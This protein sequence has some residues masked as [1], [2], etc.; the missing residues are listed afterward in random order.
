MKIFWRDNAVSEEAAARQALSL[1]EN[2]IAWYDAGCGIFFLSLLENPFRGGE[3]TLQAVSA[4]G[5]VTERLSF[6]ESGFRLRKASRPMKRY[7]SSL[8]LVLRSLRFQSSSL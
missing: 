8:S 3:S 5:A 6:F 7:D 4:I 1:W 2:G